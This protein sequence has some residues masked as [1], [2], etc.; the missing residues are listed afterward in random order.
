MSEPQIGWREWLSFVAPAGQQQII[1][2]VH[3]AREERGENWLEEIQYEFPFAA[4]IVELV[5]TKTDDEAVD[6]IAN[7]YPT[8]PIR[9]AA[10]N[11][12]KALHARLKLEIERKR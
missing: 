12:I 3:Q 10:G 8:W 7:A 4:W 2:F 6:A 9:F 1:D 11:Q 5:C